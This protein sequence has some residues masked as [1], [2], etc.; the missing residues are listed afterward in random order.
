MKAV[1]QQKAI[2]NDDLAL[3]GLLYTRDMLL[4]YEQR[5]PFQLDAQIGLAITA[6]KMTEWG[7]TEYAQEMSECNELSYHRSL[8]PNHG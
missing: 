8:H 2:G 5:D 3:D 1:D 4:E 7:Y 6:T